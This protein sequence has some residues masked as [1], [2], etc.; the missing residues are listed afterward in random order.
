[1]LSQ[2]KLVK[3]Q[4]SKTYPTA[5]GFTFTYYNGVIQNISNPTPGR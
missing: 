2:H 1:M 5:L 3:T 4:Q